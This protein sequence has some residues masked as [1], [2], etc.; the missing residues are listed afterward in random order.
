LPRIEV[1]F[2]D[3]GGTL[4]SV[5][6]DL[7]LQRFESTQ[8]LLTACRTTLGLRLGILSNT[9]AGVNRT[10]VEKILD[11]AGLLGLFDKTL[12]VTSTDAHAKKPDVAIY[13]F[14]ATK[15]AVPPERCLYIGEDVQEVDGAIAAGMAALLKPPG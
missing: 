5:S 10:R 4:G 12:I 2:F 13:R 8:P 7:V 3:I 6:P 11:T 15:A 9:P 1:V 14:A